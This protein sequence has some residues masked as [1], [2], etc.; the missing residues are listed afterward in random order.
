M[1]VVEASPGPDF[2]PR[3]I[4]DLQ[5]RPLEDIIGLSYVSE[6]LGPIYQ[7]H[8]KTVELVR[9]RTTLDKGVAF[10][11]V[12]DHCLGNINKFIPYEQYPEA[13]Y[14]VAVSH[15][16]GR[17]K[18]SVGS[19]PWHPEWR[20]HDLARICER[21][22]GGGHPVVG[23]ITYPEDDLDKAREIAASIVRELQDC[24]KSH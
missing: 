20:T 4:G 8:L 14:T 23:A 12:G 16:P 22:G 13:R 17:S 24:G 1:L 5:Q 15:G 9:S 6:R 2:I 10:Y 11:D 19:N 7:N 18:I 3:L 21:Y